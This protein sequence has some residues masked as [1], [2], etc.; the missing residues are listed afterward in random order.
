MMP[1][2]N[3]LG[4]HRNRE[5]PSSSVESHSGLNACPPRA[6]YAVALLGQP[7]RRNGAAETEPTITKS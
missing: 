5:R 6:R 1:W 2:Q 3:S 4:I 7:Q